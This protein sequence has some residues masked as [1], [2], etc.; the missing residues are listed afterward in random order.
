V[1]PTDSDEPIAAQEVRLPLEAGQK[2]QRVTM[3][4]RGTEL[5]APA[6]PTLYRLVAQL[7]RPGTPASQIEARF[8]RRT[9]EARGRSVYLNGEPVYLD[10]VL[11]QPGAASFD[12]M[13]T[14]MHA[15]QRL[16]CNLVRFHITGID[17]R[18]CGLAD[19]MGM[20]LW[21]E[22]PS[23]HSSS[24]AS[25]ENHWAEMMRMLVHIGSHPSVVIWSLYNED[26]GAQDIAT[27]PVTREYVAR[28]YDYM[29]LN[30][31]QLLVV[32]NDGWQ[33]VSMDGRLKS[34]LLTAHLYTPDL[35]QWRGLLDRLSSGETDGVAVRPLVVGDPFFAVGQVPLVVSEWGG[36]GFS[37]YGGPEELAARAERIAAFKREVRTRPIAGDVYTQAISVEDEDNGL[38]DAETGEL[39]VPEGSLGPGEPE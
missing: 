14:H 38:I 35:E 34:D 15:M 37:D 5:W 21:V 18:I 7:S 12:D 6:R 39:F 9:I 3:E 22:V 1:L 25:R 27:N 4:L 2:C 28:A 17:P 8:G 24:T 26:W 30:H 32:D 11:Y 19:E 31:P 33:H 13:Q 36:F 20:L 16:G 23:P 10:G 29:R